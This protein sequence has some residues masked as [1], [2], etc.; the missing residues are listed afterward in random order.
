MLTAHQRARAAPHHQ[1]SLTARKGK[2]HRGPWDHTSVINDSEKW[3]ANSWKPGHLAARSQGSAC[4]IGV[5]IEGCDCVRV[6]YQPMMCGVRS[7]PVCL[8][9]LCSWQI[10]DHA[11]LLAGEPC[12]Q[13]HFHRAGGD[14]GRS[15]ASQ[16]ATGKR[17]W[18]TLAN[19]STERCFP[20]QLF[21]ILLKIPCTP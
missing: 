18:Q 5:N 12:G 8:T 4:Q 6:D 7:C 16:C 19:S 15:A 9:D 20:G 1:I 14:T 3:E 10:P 17:P 13:T 2:Q 11:G 21:T